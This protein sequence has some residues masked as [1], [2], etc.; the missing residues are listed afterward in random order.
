ML[1]EIAVARKKLKTQQQQQGKG[2]H[3]IILTDSIEDEKKLVAMVLDIIE[4]AI[5]NKVPVET[6]FQRFVD[7]GAQ[8]GRLKK[9]KTM[10][11]PENVVDIMSTPPLPSP[12]KIIEEQAPTQ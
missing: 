9:A 11:T 6:Q 10:K 7:T 2:K 4:D 5:A 8:V 12:T 3:N 1:K